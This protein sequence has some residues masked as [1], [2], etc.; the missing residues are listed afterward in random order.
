MTE[1]EHNDEGD[2]E[3]IED[4]EAPAAMQDDVAGGG[5]VRPTCAGPTK[6]VVVC[7]EPTCADTA[8]ECEAATHSLILHQS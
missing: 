8:A 4:L 3:A 1:T 7:Q 2:E 6:L 5:C